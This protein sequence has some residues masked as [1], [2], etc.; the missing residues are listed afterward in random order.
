MS[1]LL[2]EFTFEKPPSKIIYFDKEP[3]KL[4]NEFMFFHNKNKFR[5][6]LVRLQNLIKSYTKSP[7]HAAG[8]RDS[9]LKEEFSEEY[10]IIIF[11][12]PETIKKANEIIENH[13]NIEVNK[14]CFFLKADTNFVLLL[15]RDM[16]G[17]IL[18]IDIIEVI[19][20]QILEDYMNQEKFDDYIKIC[21]FE[22][23]DCSKSA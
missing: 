4:S 16:E 19:L 15:S 9:Y 6:D 2:K 5:K 23:N 8:I 17:L 18:G 13:S 11:A 12:T 14:G 10:L 3:L 1:E 7:L 22:L 21:S 20:K